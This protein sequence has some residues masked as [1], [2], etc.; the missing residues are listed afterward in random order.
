ME[1]YNNFL[2]G[3]KFIKQYFLKFPDGKKMH[4]WIYIKDNS[5]LIYGHKIN[6]LNGRDEFYDSEEERDFFELPELES[7]VTMSLSMVAFQANA[8]MRVLEFSPNVDLEEQM[9]SMKEIGAEG[10]LDVRDSQ[11]RKE[12]IK[13]LEF[14]YNGGRKMREKKEKKIKE[15]TSSTEWLLSKIKEWEYSNLNKGRIVE[16]F[17]S[18]FAVEPDNDDKVKN[19]RVFAF[20][21]KKTILN[22]LKDISKE[23]KKEKED[24]IN[25]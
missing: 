10:S 12:E 2:S 6:H 23:I 20:G 1:N 18:F 4:A 16:F 5:K 14:L 15:D 11:K 13:K 24:F 22:T 17:G 7:K 19:D 8:K 25:W 21:L 3:G 9:E